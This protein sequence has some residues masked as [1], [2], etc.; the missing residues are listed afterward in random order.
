MFQQML[1]TQWKSVRSG[2]IPIAI[3]S[4][5]LP[6]LAVQDLALPGDLAAGA[7]LRAIQAEF[8]FES[9]TIWL[10]FFPVLA[11]ILGVIFAINA[12]SGDHT[13]GH[14]YALALPLPRWKYVLWKMGAGTL[15]LLIPVAFLGVG[16]I[17]AVGSLDL[18]EGLHAYP[19]LFTQRFLMATLLAYGAL[20]A[21]ASGTVRTATLVVSV[22]L[23]V[24]FG[25]EFL[26]FYLS[27]MLPAFDWHLFDWVERVMVEWP[28]PL[29]VYFGNWN[30]I[31]V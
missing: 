1:F 9:W 15:L 30:L 19:L 24:L 3:A 16:S 26:T 14:V 8:I 5:G 31:D 11:A 10:P 28:G 29:E 2:L 20:F 21:M 7:P 12:W 25:G 6:L 13:A 17:V 18:A 27:E 22:G 4:F 23:T